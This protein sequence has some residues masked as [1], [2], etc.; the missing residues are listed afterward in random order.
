MH[1]IWPILSQ[2]CLYLASAAALMYVLGR[3]PKHPWCRKCNYD[4]SSQAA[5]PG[6]WTCPEC[7]RRYTRAKQ[8]R[9]RRRSRWAAFGAIVLL[10]GWYAAGVTPRVRARGWVGAIPTRVLAAW[11]PW[12]LQASHPPGPIWMEAELALRTHNSNQEF[13]WPTD[14]IYALRTR[15]YFESHPE[16]GA[17]FTAPVPDLERRGVVPRVLI[18]AD[19]GNWANLDDYLDDKAPTGWSANDA[20]K[21]QY[22]LTRFQNFC[23]DSLGLCH[24]QRIRNTWFV[25]S[26]DRLRAG[27][28]AANLRLFDQAVRGGPDSTEPAGEAS[29]A[30]ARALSETRISVPPG[31]ATVGQLLDVVSHASG[32]PM[33]P[34]SSPLIAFDATLLLEV[35]VPPSNR[36][37][38]FLDDVLLAAEHARGHPDAA[39]IPRWTILD[40][41]LALVDRDFELFRRGYVGAVYNLSDIS[42][43][44]ATSGDTPGEIVRAMFRGLSLPSSDASQPGRVVAFSSYDF[45]FIAPAAPSGLYMLGSAP[46]HDALR[47]LL[48]A[49]RAGQQVRYADGTSDAPFRLKAK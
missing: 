6:P 26:D 41:K 2:S 14:S 3:R 25:A 18:G 16:D 27:R 10:G 35:D 36:A 39:K 17:F 21:T 30:A 43:E 8:L 42:V 47:R 28:V 20:P 22:F 13:A 5:Q 7:G 40:G 9:R 23:S 11:I 32:V 46:D 48:A 49:L 33:S 29:I 34:E 19:S 12:E 1:D 38:D 4:L 37:S 44:G 31:R 45:G 24:V 15:L